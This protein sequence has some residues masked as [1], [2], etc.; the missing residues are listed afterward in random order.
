[1]RLVR[2]HAN[3]EAHLGPRLRN[4]LALCDFLA[5]LGGEHDEASHK[6][7]LART[8]HDGVEVGRE[9]LTRQVT[10]RINHRT[11]VPGAA[12]DASS[13]IGAPPSGL[14]AST[15]PFDSMPINFAGCRF[16]TTTTVLPTSASGS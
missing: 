16:A 2:M 9:L 6:T 10:V 4:L 8:L 14:A 1:M 15:I 13:T 7:R 3:R 11:R 5:I 12:G